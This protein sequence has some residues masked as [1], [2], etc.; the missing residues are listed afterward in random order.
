MSVFQWGEGMGKGQY[1]GTGKIRV[2][3]GVYEIICVKL[4]KIVK[5]YRI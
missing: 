3:L 2:I 1:R 5:N 4:L